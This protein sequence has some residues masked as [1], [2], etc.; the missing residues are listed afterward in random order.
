VEWELA[1]KY[2]TLLSLHNVC[3][4][5]YARMYIYMYRLEE[6]GREPACRYVV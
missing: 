3:D 5:M 4:I 1:E 6:V 2:S